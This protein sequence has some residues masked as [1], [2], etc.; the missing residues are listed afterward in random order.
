MQ[1]YLALLVLVLAL[2]LPAVAAAQGGNLTM[3]DIELTE[4]GMLVGVLQNPTATKHTDITVDLSLRDTQGNVLWTGTERR[5]GLN[6]RQRVRVSKRIGRTFDEP[7]QVRYSIT[8]TPDEIPAEE[9]LQGDVPTGADPD[10][11]PSEDLD[12]LGEEH[13]DPK[14]QGDVNLEVQRNEDGSFTISN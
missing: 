13:A 11:Y 5:M 4:D 7:V 12:D 3:S 9:L 6:P 1:R 14:A 10:A 8:S 2:T